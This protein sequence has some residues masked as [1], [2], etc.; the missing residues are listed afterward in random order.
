M[1]WSRVDATSPAA[2][3]AIE[4]LLD[5]AIS[6]GIE[7]HKSLQVRERD[8]QI[9]LHADAPRGDVLVR[10]PEDLLVPVAETGWGTSDDVL[11]IA[12]HDPTASA[13]QR[14]LI[15]AHLAV[16]N[17][18][19]KIRW[20]RNTLPVMVLSRDAAVAS[21]VR[22]LRPSFPQESPSTAEGFINTRLY[23]QAVTCDGVLMPVIDFL[24][25]HRR[26]AKLLIDDGAMTVRVEHAAGDMQCFASYGSRRDLLDLALGYGF[27]DPAVR[28]ARSLAVS[29]D[30]P[31]FG[32]VEVLGRRR[33]AVSSLDP[34][35]ITMER[36]RL[37]L[38][39]LSF[40]AEHPDRVVSVLQLA[41]GSYLAQHV[42]PPH[43]PLL[44]ARAVVA[45]LASANIDLLRRAESQL[46]DSTTEAAHVLS[47]AISGQRDIIEQVRRN[48]MQA[49]L[50]LH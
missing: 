45:A 9:S 17:S 47:A 2:K 46:A 3:A 39:H 27:V 4:D 28:F 36:K 49:S 50:P 19:G 25:H 35:Q 30:I 38:S 10:V 5:C 23:Q 11:S 12:R 21:T 14:E 43:E 48:A 31:G 22:L 34:P 18:T 16:Y 33:E 7:V 26:G 20:A 37:S 44:T 8:G 42:D 6:S 29:T 15:E 1:V 13:P 24:N 41:V 40:H 32:N